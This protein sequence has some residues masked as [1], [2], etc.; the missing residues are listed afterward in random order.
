MLL[1][2]LGATMSMFIIFVGWYSFTIAGN[3]VANMV[4]VQLP[5]ACFGNVCAAQFASQVMGL[6]EIAIGV[7]FLF[8]VVYLALSAGQDDPQSFTVGFD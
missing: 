7:C 6:F 3:A 4:V 5:N 2:A 8:I 1:K